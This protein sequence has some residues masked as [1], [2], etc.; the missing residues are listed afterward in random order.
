MKDYTQHR[1]A[2]MQ[3]L[4]ALDVRLHAIEADLEQPHSKDWNDA[5]IEQEGDEV[6]EGLGLAGDAEMRR[7]GAALKRM[8]TDQYGVCTLC[9]KTIALARLDAVPEAA[10]CHKCA[11]K[12]D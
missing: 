11:G 6:L 10:L 4:A 12:T 7:I 8:R 3:R 2:L 5:A 9:H 1:T